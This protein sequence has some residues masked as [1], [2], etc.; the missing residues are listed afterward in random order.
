MLAK[1]FYK[2]GLGTSLI[3]EENYPEEVHRYLL[4]ERELFGAV[5]MDFKVITE[6][7]CMHGR[8]LDCVLE[9]DRCYLGIDIV[10]S[11]LKEGEAIAKLKSHG[12]GRY[13][14]ECV[15]ARQ[16]HEKVGM[17]NVFGSSPCDNL[18]LYPFNSIGNMTG[19]DAVI[20]SLVHSKYPFLIC[21]YKTDKESTLVRFDYYNRCRYNQ[22]TCIHMENG[23]RFISSDGLDTTAYERNWFINK[24][25][26]MGAV[27]YP[28]P[29]SKIGV[30]YTNSWTIV[31]KQQEVKIC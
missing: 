4:A 7:G 14:F 19:I 3:L 16:I 18:I 24:F 21:T 28:I 12:S 13:R 5:V 20:S 2:S 31:Q 29:I 26:E 15:D 25:L 22:L 23:I 6:V 9:N 30:A 1:D 10:E 27:I 8:Y 11:Y 17:E